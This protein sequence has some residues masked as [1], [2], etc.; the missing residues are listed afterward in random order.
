MQYQLGQ[1]IRKRYEGFLSTAYNPD[2]IYVQSSDFER[3]IRS[4]MANMGGLYPPLPEDPSPAGSREQF[5]PVHSL[6]STI[7]NVIIPE[8]ILLT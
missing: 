2:E 1:Y 7:D 8:K 6:P 3:T 4:A 5:V